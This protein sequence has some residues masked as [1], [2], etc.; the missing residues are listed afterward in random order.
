MANKRA[1]PKRA[2]SKKQYSDMTDREL[3]SHLN[4]EE[5][6]RAESFTKMNF[7]HGI[8]GRQPHESD[9]QHL[10]RR[11]E[12]LA[13]NASEYKILLRKNLERVLY[14][15]DQQKQRRL[16]DLLMPTPEQAAKDAKAEK[17]R[18]A[19]QAADF[20]VYHPRTADEARPDYTLRDHITPK[21]KKGRGLPRAGKPKVEGGKND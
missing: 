8:P 13:V 19:K 4:P 12:A 16:E 14:D 3:L 17:E 11:R 9:G 2:L 6:K 21:P 18:L 1:I 5:R 10:K 15:S 20:G 7:G